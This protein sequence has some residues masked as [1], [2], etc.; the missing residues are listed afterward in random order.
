M[1]F[2]I[3]YTKK[4]FLSLKVVAFFVRWGLMRKYLLHFKKGFSLISLR[5]STIS[6]RHGLAYCVSLL[7]ICLTATVFSWKKAQRSAFDSINNLREFAIRGKRSDGIRSFAR[8]GH[9]MTQVHKFQI[10]S[11][12]FS[13]LEIYRIG[14]KQVLGEVASN[15]G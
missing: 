15:I 11:Y 12:K 13:V 5:I 3:F 7:V 1:R 4:S 2:S 6:T 14:F 8:P 9:Y 10:A